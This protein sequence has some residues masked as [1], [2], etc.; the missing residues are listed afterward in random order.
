MFENIMKFFKKAIQDEDSKLIGNS[1]INSATNPKSNTVTNSNSK[2]N[3]GTN[4]HSRTK[5]KE[6]LHLVLVQDRVNVSADFLDLM[7]QEI[8]DVIKKYIDIDEAAMDVS[9]TNRENED[10]TKGTPALYAN[11]PILNIKDETRKIGNKIELKKLKDKENPP[12]KEE[13]NGQ[14]VKVENKKA[15]DIKEISKK[16]NK[17]DNL[18]KEKDEQDNKL[19]ETQEAV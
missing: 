12:K 3:V 18:N 1:S 4:A 11:I 13:K 19:S 15:E 2:T 10:G 6:R 17:E 8:I 16:D 14:E 9:L 5:A 7:K